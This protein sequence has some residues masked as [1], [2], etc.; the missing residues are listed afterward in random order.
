MPQPEPPV[1][2]YDLVA[3]VSNDLVTDQRM[4]KSLTSLTSA[5]YR[6][7][8]LGR[9]KPQSNALD[10]RLPFAQERH[11]LQA[12]DGKRFYW[13]LN[14]AHLRRLIDLRPRA[15]LAVDLDTVWAAR[16]ASRKLGVPFAFDAHELFEEQPEVARRP[17]IKAIWYAVGK[18][19]VPH[20]AVCYT[21]G[22]GLAKVLSARYGRPFSVVRNFPTPNVAPR[23]ARV[24]PKGESPFTVIYQG[25]L[26]EGRGLAELIQA[27]QQLPEVGFWIVGDG[28]EATELRAFAKTCH[29]SNVVFLGE[30]GPEALAELTPRADLGYALMSRRGLNYYLSLSNKSVDYL[31]AGLPSLQ[32]AWPEYERIHER[33]SCYYLVDELHVE[34]VI[35]AVRACRH[36]ATY[37][38]LAEGSARAGRHLTWEREEATLIA[39]FRSMLPP[40][41]TRSQAD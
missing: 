2:R 26:N 17:W 13:Q 30:L 11:R 19:F 41:K 40:L 5:G 4:Q 8:L 14:R 27:A 38:R 36:A 20:A 37:D 32:M 15:I 34:A 24:L 22:E 10:P 29:A 3:L 9:E 7:L 28:P 18:R 21:V 25:A 12:Q 33:W 39:A 1:S 35:A 16:R 31:R 23:A 6:C